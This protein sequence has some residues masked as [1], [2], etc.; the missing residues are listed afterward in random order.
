M[1]LKFST[2]AEVRRALSKIANMLVNGDIDPQRATALTNCANAILNCIRLDE[3]ARQIAALEA[4][5]K[6]L[7]GHD[8]Y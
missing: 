5:L 8:R 1:K 6:E 4:E 2:P 7:E 3:Q